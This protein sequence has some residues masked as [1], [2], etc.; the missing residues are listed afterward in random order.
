MF[1]IVSILLLFTSLGYSLQAVVNPVRLYCVSKGI[2]KMTDRED[3]YHVCVNN[4]KYIKIVEN[5]NKRSTGP[6]MPV[7]SDIDQKVQE[8]CECDGPNMI[9]IK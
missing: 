8:S 4:L 1:K 5:I 6:L 7:Y 3:A 9:E 2:M